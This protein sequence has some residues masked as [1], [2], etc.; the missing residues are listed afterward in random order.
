[1]KLAAAL[2]LL[3][4]SFFSVQSARAEFFGSG[5]NTF[6]IPF[7]TIGDFTLWG[8]AFGE[9]GMGLPDDLSGDNQIDIGDFTI[10]GDNFGNTLGVGDGAS[11]TSAVPEPSSMVLVGTGVACLVVFA[12]RRRRVA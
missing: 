6:E 4:F 11:S 3:A 7:V 5:T 12:R 2:A 1:M 9:T 10:W 8:D